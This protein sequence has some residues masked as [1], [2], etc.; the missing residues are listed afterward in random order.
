MEYGVYLK[1]SMARIFNSRFGNLAGAGITQFPA[2]PPI[3]IGVYSI[4]SYSSALH[5]VHTEGNS[6]ANVYRGVHVEGI[7]NYDVVNCQ[8]SVNQTSPNVR[9]NAAVFATNTIEGANVH[10]N[11]VHNFSTG[12]Y[13]GY[14]TPSAAANFTMSVFENTITALGTAAAYCAEGISLDDGINSFNA[15]GRR[16]LLSTNSLS[17]VQTGI[18]VTNFKYGLRISNNT[19][20]IQ[21]ASVGLRSGIRL[22]G[23][24]R[25][26]VD[27][28]TI[29]STGTSN[30]NLR[31]MFIQLSPGCQVNCNTINTVGQSVLYEGNCLMNFI[32]FI[33]NT[34]NTA[35]DGFVLRNNGVVGQIGRYGGGII[36]R[37]S[38]NNQWLGTFTNSKTLVMDQGSSAL[39]SPMFVRNTLTE[40]PQP[41][42]LNKW[43]NSAIVSVDNYGTSTFNGAN[44]SIFVYTSPALPCTTPNTTGQKTASPDSTEQANTK[45]ANDST[46]FNLLQG[47]GSDAV[48]E[49]E[50][51]EANRNYVYCVLK[52]DYTTTHA[53]LTAFYTE[54]Q[55]STIADYTDID[56]LIA[57]G[58]L[59]AAQNR[60]SGIAASSLMQQTSRW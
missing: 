10:N 52:E 35:N 23:T 43:A 21:Y 58:N 16:I 20:G 11:T 40:L 42:A 48:L 6:F 15:S 8:F 9:G 60:N 34:M 26:I 32:G 51:R 44:A 3:G 39:N 30:L 22:N 27:N 57:E 33:N 45:M 4:N 59:I 53:G 2:P 29:S 37:Y 46:L 12:F 14:S 54:Q 25:A 47:P 55:D 24:E 41:Q 49:S 38:A 56:S 31:G 13:H 19:I 36:S 7:N 28:N 18:R 1:N 17:T 50:T 5:K